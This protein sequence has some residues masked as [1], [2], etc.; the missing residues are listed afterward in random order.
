MTANDERGRVSPTVL[1][2][3][4]CLQFGDTLTAGNVTKYGVVWDR[5]LEPYSVLAERRPGGSYLS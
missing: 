3:V 4:T 2:N 1:A 5:G